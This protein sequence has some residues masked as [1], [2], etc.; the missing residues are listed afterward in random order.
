MECPKVIIDGLP[1]IEIIAG[2]F[3]FKIRAGDRCWKHAY[4]PAQIQRTLGLVQSLLEDFHRRQGV[5]FLERH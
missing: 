4:T 1:E 3:I 5:Q 2:L